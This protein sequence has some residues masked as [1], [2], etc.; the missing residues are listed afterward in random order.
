MRNVRKPVEVSKR[1]FNHYGNYDHT[2]PA[3]YEP[4]VGVSS[5]IPNQS[6]SIERAIELLA[7]NQPVPMT[8]PVYSPVEILDF[9][10]LDIV[11]LKDFVSRLDEQEFDLR[12]VADKLAADKAAAKAEHKKKE[13]TSLINEIK[14]LSLK[15]DN[16]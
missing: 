2:Q 16:S 12:E 3:V 5:V 10:K 1:F 8:Q 9:R 11:E 15:H 14:E 4:V 7:T 6:Y 13:K